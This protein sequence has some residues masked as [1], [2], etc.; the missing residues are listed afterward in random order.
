[1]S[2]I[3][4]HAASILAQKGVVVVQ[5][6]GNEGD[7]DWHYIIRPADAFN[8]LAVGNV[9]KNGILSYTSSYGPS[10]DGRIKPDVAS[11]GK[12]WF[13]WSNGQIMEDYSS[14]S[15]SGAAPIIAGLS[16]CLWQALPQ[17]SSLEIMQLIREYGDIANNPDDRKGYG[18]PNFY[19]CY[20]DHYIGVSEKVVPEIEVYPNPTTGQL[21]I[22]NGQLTIN[23]IEIYDVFGRKQSSNHLI[24]SSSHHLINIAHLQAGIYFVRIQ[25]EKG[26]VGKKIVKTNN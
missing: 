16:A 25:T 5:A 12:G 21:T 24:T 13:V 9:D 3:A 4:S 2:S 26:M 19:Q 11:M 8:I 7:T 18:I 22:E 23:N 10:T 20:K 17:Y 14:G 1:V 6:A 15:T